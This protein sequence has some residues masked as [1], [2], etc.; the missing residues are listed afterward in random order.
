MLCP[1]FES[2]FKFTKFFFYFLPNIASI[3]PIEAYCTRFIL[4]AI[5]FNWEDRSDVWK[6]VK[7]ELGELEEA[8]EQGTQQ[9]AE[10]EFG[11]F[12]FSLI[13]ASR[14]YKLNPD[15]ALESTNQKFI[16]RFNYIEEQCKVAGRELQQM[17]LAEMDILWDEAKS[18]GL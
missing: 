17:T 18:K 10:G 6:K 11:D 3:F 1:L 5:G 16:R 12:L 13:N 4:Y 14:L 2:F 8:L 9:E 15:N 7:E